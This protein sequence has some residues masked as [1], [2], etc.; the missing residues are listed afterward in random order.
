MGSI[1]PRGPN[2]SA[3]FGS[4]VIGFT[5]QDMISKPQPKSNL[6]NSRNSRPETLYVE[7]H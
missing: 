2:C 1:V 5:L 6:R 7:A 4:S 3:T